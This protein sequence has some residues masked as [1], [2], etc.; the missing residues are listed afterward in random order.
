MTIAI[1]LKVN[2][3]VV[4]AAD[5]A[6]TLMI[7]GPT[8]QSG[9][10]QVYN[11]ANKIVNL[12][13]GLPIGAITWGQGAIGQSSTSTLLKDLRKRLAGSAKGYEEWAIEPESYTIADVA[14]RLRNFMF[15]ENYN[16]AFRDWAQKP[17][18]GFIVAG[19]SAS[20]APDEYKVEIKNGACDPPTEVRKSGECGVTWNGEP[21][22]IHRL[23]FGFSPHLAGVLKNQL[24][25]PPEQ[26]GPTLEILRRALT[27]PLIADAMPI[28]DAIDLAEFLVDLTERFSRFTPGAPTVGG[29]IE[30]AAITKHEGFKW[31]KRKL[32]FERRLNPEARL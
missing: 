10:G 3:G 7:Q 17:S 20:G 14:A 4:L 18:L 8:G 1:S 16:P 26:I 21:E 15:E 5:S 23:L 19:Y 2:D 31:A 6:S 11:N 13:K 27:A 32:Y 28:Q 9:V 25:V 29:P 12:C 30:I 24:Q 22:A